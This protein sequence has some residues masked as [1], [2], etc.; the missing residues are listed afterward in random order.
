MTIKLNGT[1]LRNIALFALPHVTRSITQP[2]R[3]CSCLYAKEHVITYIFDACSLLNVPH[4]TPRHQPAHYLELLKG[5][6]PTTHVADA[7]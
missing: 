6:P 7:K 3:V 5:S 4:H 2:S 1:P